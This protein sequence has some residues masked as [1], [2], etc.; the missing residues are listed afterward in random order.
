[1]TPDASGVDVLHGYVPGLLARCTELHALYYS[2]H[3][4]FGRAFEAGVSGGLAEFAGRMDNPDNRMWRAIAGD[5]I[6]GILAVDGEDLGDG[7]AHLRWFIVD[8]AARGA[9]VGR[10]LLAAALDFCDSHGF[11]EIHLWTFRGLDA[12]RH[13][14]EANGFRLVDERPGEQW[15]AR[16]QEQRFVRRRP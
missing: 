13:L 11:P 5:R 16:V 9:G 10:R 4:G 1:M 7:R 2:R 6:A 3:S 8:D 14:Y 12:A 15:G